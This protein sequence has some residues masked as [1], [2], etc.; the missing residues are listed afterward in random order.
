[1]AARKL[2]A[3]PNDAINRYPYVKC[4]VFRHKFEPVGPIPGRS[5]A[6]QFGTLI[7]LR[8]DECGGL[9][10]DV[11]SRLTGDLLYRWYELADDYKTPAETMAHWRVVLM[12]DLD[13]RML[14]DLS[15]QDE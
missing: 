1:M 10:F 5:R 11:V 12:D 2:A 9:R 15:D 7:T 14:V 4:K 8:C 3:V 6:K 13:N